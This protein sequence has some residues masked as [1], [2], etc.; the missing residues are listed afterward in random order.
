MSA[1]WVDVAARNEIPHQGAQRI[2]IGDV[3]V[4]I[5]CSQDG[6]MFALIDRCPHKGGPLSQG[7]VHGRAIACPLH[8]W[9][10]SLETGQARAPDKGCAH[11]LGVEL[12]DGRVRLDV[13]R[14]KS[15]AP[16][17]AL[18]EA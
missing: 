14:L 13:S 6:A 15:V 3:P 11:T 7:I 2:M 9:S 8:N 5:F 18:V 10:I 4:A 16:P 12:V 1:L 17:Q